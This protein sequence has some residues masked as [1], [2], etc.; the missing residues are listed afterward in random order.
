MTPF[1][2][3][4]PAV[5]EGGGGEEG[6]RSQD[7]DHN[8]NNFLN[9]RNSC[10]SPEKRNQCSKEGCTGSR[11][12]QQWDC[13]ILL[14]DLQ[15]PTLPAPRDDRLVRDGALAAL[16]RSKGRDTENTC[17][18]VSFLLLSRLASPE[19]TLLLNR[20]RALQIRP[21]TFTTTEVH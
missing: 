3:R 19:Q 9:H 16:L 12:N 7:G 5:S 4:V 15:A 2:N 21:L 11:D 13:R 1:D 10:K 17:S 8:R 6:A 18:L 14:Q 20:R